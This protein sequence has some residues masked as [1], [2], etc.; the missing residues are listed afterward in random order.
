MNDSGLVRNKRTP[1]ASV[2]LGRSSVSADVLVPSAKPVP[3]AAA[4]ASGGL[5]SL[6]AA[7]GREPLPPRDD[8]EEDA[9]DTAGQDKR[10]LAVR[11]DTNGGRFRDFRSCVENFKE[12]PWDDWPIP[13]PRTTGW[14]CTWMLNRSCTPL[15]WH[16]QWKAAGRLQDQEG[17]VVQHEF[18]CRA[19]ETL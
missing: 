6:A 9:A 11:Y 5:A 2:G 10:T 13:G 15:S 3:K 7:L 4:T 18:C 16:Q 12:T 1:G 8:D 14:V 19:L 17:L